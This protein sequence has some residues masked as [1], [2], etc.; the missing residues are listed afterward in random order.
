MR[1]AD[2]KEW[3]RATLRHEDTG[4]VPYQFLP[5]PVALQRII[6]HYGPDPANAVRIPIRMNGPKSIKP[7]YAD[8]KQYGPK[9][10]DEFGVLW[11]TS[12]IDRGSPLDPVLREPDLSKYQ[13]PAVDLNYRFEDL[14]AWCRKEETHFRFMWVGDLWERA[15]FMR[16]ME[17]LL[18]DVV[19]NRSFVQGLLRALADRVL[20]TMEILFDRFDF[21][22]IAMSDDY[23]VQRSLLISP[24]DWRKLVKPLLAEIYGMAKS[25]GKVVFHHT[26]GHV[27]PIIRDMIDIGLDILHPIQPEAMDIFAL[28]RDFGKEVTLCGG[29]PTQTLLVQG[30]PEQVKAEVRRLKRE[31]G[32]GGGYILEPGI[33]LQADIPP[34]NIVAMIDEAMK[35]SA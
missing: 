15:T 5:S 21:E 1:P 29:I 7:L 3:I 35:E 17:D 20:E 12:P 23:G 32:R 14:A 13:F 31:M 33:T 18:M 22:G 8:P 34:E 6:A 24:E 11:T 9:A 27:V 26:C 19:L 4:A 28:K 25:R 16:G 2:D 30:T 10:I